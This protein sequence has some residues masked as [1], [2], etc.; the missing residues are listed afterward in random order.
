M[1]R[2]EVGFKLDMKELISKTTLLPEQIERNIYLS[3]DYAAD[4]GQAKMKMEAP[5]TDRTGAA[6]SGLFVLKRHQ[7]IPGSPY[8]RHELIFAHGVDYGIWLE[9]ANSGKYQILMPTVKQVGHDLMAGLKGLLEHPNVPVQGIFKELEPSPGIR[10][11]T[12]QGVNVRTERE[13]RRM[14]RVTRRYVR[15]MVRKGWQGV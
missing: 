11:G 14:R 2:V 4:Y 8:G 9:V 10:K 1:S 13:I 5:W 7:D 15:R 3:V 12:S 6:R